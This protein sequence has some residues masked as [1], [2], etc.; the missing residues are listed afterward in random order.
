MSMVIVS[1]VDWSTSGVVSNAGVRALIVFT[2]LI[3]SFAESSRV[4]EERFAGARLIR[5]MRTRDVDTHAT[6][7]YS[8]RHFHRNHRY[9]NGFC[10]IPNRSSRQ[11][12]RL[13]LINER[14]RCLA[15][16]VSSIHSRTRLA[17]LGLPP[18]ELDDDDR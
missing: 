12:A 3:V 4:R 2:S 15:K 1:V 9:R 16:E 6:R 17:K 14:E 5:S 8:P 18:L 10:S 7:E 11:C 13:V